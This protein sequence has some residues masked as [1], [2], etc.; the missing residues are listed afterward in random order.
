[1]VRL[2]APVAWSSVSR[3]F[4]PCAVIPT[5]DNPTTIGDVVRGVRERI[6]NLIVV[7]DGSARAGQQAVGALATLPGVRVYRRER[8]GG[9]GAAVKTGLDLALQSGFSH[10]LQFD[11]DGQHQIDDIPRFLEA[12]RENPEALILGSPVFDDSAPRSR[13]IGRSITRFWTNIETYW[14]GAIDDPMCGFRVYPLVESTRAGARGN[15]MD[16]DPEIAVRL[17][18]RNVP[19]VNLKTRVRY[20]DPDSG[21]VTHFRLFRD[22]ALISWMHTRMV[23]GAALRLLRRP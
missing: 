9:K 8:N 4:H 21:G 18:W 6:P 17:A 12:A 10:A 11:A 23:T 15:A 22:N 13:V 5:Y 7:D 19:I 2:V 16:F 1:M 3:K 20:F 14:S